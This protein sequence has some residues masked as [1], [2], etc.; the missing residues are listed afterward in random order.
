MLKK[1]N[2]EEFQE[3]DSIENLHL[4]ATKR[5]SLKTDT[6]TKREEAVSRA[7]EEAAAVSVVKE[8]AA[9]AL[10]AKEEVAPAMVTKEEEAVVSKAKVAA[11]A[12]KEKEVAA[13]SKAKEAKEGKEVKVKV[14]E[15]N[16]KVVE[17]RKDENKT[18]VINFN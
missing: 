9:A 2:L 4:S 17:N 6:K 10:V 7:K 12:P 5:P 18:S 15:A 13:V 14:V 8:A 11:A 3:E 16:H 1:V